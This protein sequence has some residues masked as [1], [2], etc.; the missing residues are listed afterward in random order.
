MNALA[1][2]IFKSNFS[3]FVPRLTDDDYILK[4]QGDQFNLIAKNNANFNGW[5]PSKYIYVRRE[6]DGVNKSFLYRLIDSPRNKVAYELIPT[7]F[8]TFFIKDYTNKTITIDGKTLSASVLFEEKAKTNKEN[9]RKKREQIQ[10]ENDAFA[11]LTI[12]DDPLLKRGN[13]SPKSGNELF[14]SL[15]SMENIPEFNK[16]AIEPPIEY[17]EKDI[18]K[19][20]DVDFKNDIKT[21]E[22]I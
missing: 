13:I 14:D 6:V 1:D 7:P 3:K 15:P 18:C 10:T 11:H 2:L 12:N 22:S 9:L 19:P 8:N 20:G 5:S 17:N 16:E 4:Q 21:G